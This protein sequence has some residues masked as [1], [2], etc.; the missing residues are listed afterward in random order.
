MFRYRRQSAYSAT[1]IRLVLT[2]VGIAAVVLLIASGC[3]SAI[4]A[5]S[6]MIDDTVGAIGESREDD[7][8]MDGSM[9]DEETGSDETTST[10]N[11]SL[12][13]GMADLQNVM[14]FNVA[15]LQVVFLGGH[16]PG[17]EDFR[18]GEGVKWEITGGDG[19]D[20]ASFVA[21]R[22]LIR[23][24]TDGTSWWFLGYS[25]EGEVM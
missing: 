25:S 16:D 22:A 9:S 17:F 7:A 19:S 20:Q 6:G 10:G 8:K 12:F 14:L 3:A 11:Q 5:V 15:Y 21:E 24:N 4:S 2:G 1:G 13:G 18:E 23:R